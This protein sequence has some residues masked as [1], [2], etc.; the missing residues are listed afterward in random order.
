MPPKH[1]D[2]NDVLFALGQKG[3]GAIFLGNITLFNLKDQEN[4]LNGQVKSSEKISKKYASFC[5][6]GILFHFILFS[7]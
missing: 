3:I 1:S 7:A 6:R 5:K 2:G 4:K